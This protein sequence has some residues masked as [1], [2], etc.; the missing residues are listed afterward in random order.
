[1]ILT[2]S[3]CRTTVCECR[4]SSEIRK[5]KRKNG[6]QTKSRIRFQKFISSLQK[7]RMF[8][9]DKVSG[10]LV[11]VLINANFDGRH[12][13]VCY[14]CKNFIQFW[15]NKSCRMQINKIRRIYSLWYNKIFVLIISGKISGRFF[16]KFT[17]VIFNQLPDAIFNKANYFAGNYE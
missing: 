2:N 6:K 5:I 14:I 17:P 12:K 1:M 7:V 11:K 15:L 13:N 9:V 3:V 4:I 16:G 8:H 10:K